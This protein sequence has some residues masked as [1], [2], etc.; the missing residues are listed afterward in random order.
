MTGD[1]RALRGLGADERRRIVCFAEV[2]ERQSS[3]VEGARRTGVLAYVVTVSLR[4]RGRRVAALLEN[5][6]PSFTSFMTVLILSGG[7]RRAAALEKGWRYSC[8]LRGG[9]SDRR[10]TGGA[11]V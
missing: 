11:K 5:E 2:S 7:E 9:R 6:G 10:V 4:D 8:P 1:A 3:N